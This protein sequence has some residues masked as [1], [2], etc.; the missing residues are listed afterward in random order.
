MLSD[1]D[2]EFNKLLCYF[3][4][5]L[6]SAVV[7]VTIGDI[8][9]NGPIFKTADLSTYISEN[10]A[11]P[12]SVITLA[13][14]TTDPDVPPNQGPYRYRTVSGAHNNYF[15]IDSNTGLVETKVSLDRES[16]AEFDI[17]VIVEDGGSPKMSSTLTFHVAVDDINDV[18]STARQMTIKTFLYESH[19]PS[20]TIADVKPLD[21]DTV[22]EYSCQLT[23]DPSVV[24]DIPDHCN[25]HLL[26][27]PNLD[28][29]SLQIT[30]DDGLH[31]SVSY[32]A[33]VEF[34][35]LHGDIVNRSTVLRISRQHLSM[36]VQNRYQS[37]LTF[38]S[39]LFTGNYEVAMYSV[40]QHREDVLIVLAVK[41]QTTNVYRLANDVAVTIESVKS[42]IEQD[43]GITIADP[44]YRTCSSQPCVNAI[45]CEDWLQIGNEMETADS[46][47]LI[48]SHPTVG[49]QFRC[50]CNPS[51]TGITCDTP[52]SQCGNLYCLNG[53][54]C[55]NDGCLCPSSWTGPSCEVDVNECL[56]KP[57]KNN[58][59]CVNHDGGFK[60]ECVGVFTGKL[61]DDNGMDDCVNEPCQ[62]GGHCQKRDDGTYC[63]CSYSFWGQ[64]CH[65]MT[66]SFEDSSYMQLPT[67]DEDTNDIRIQFA[68]NRRDSL[69]LY[70]PGP[71]EF[72][73]LEI[74]DGEVQFSFSLG[75]AEA[76]R[77]RVPVHVS[78]GEWYQVEAQRNG[79]VRLYIAYEAC[80]QK[81][82]PFYPDLNGQYANLAYS[83]MA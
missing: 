24:F 38:L 64:S 82:I 58:G 12:A 55:E 51:F 69:L 16:N 25:L 40:K 48:I 9:D 60:C 65:L 29:Y 46:D 36:F 71:T 35:E 20:T 45:A 50:T 4:S 32:T 14:F 70:N 7:L 72:I 53:G 56:N 22:G 80:A 47:H 11:A 28:E 78:D 49:F 27:V 43:V 17:P 5:F 63:Q 26:S 30:G 76:T 44:A 19:V 61:C 62:N 81:L 77:L 23:G 33:S 41:H 8:N 37:L 18:P 39:N 79:K 83:C 67:I 52:I 42:Q 6:G 74:I 57:C 34:W 54:T 68:S 21:A 59:Y 3:Y 75:D 13:M 2:A 15:T 73:A 66:F 1:V 31:P 10:I